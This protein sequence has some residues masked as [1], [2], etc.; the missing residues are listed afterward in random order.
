MRWEKL[1]CGLAAAWWAA[2]FLAGLVGVAAEYAA[3]RDWLGFRWPFAVIA[4]ALITWTPLNIFFC[5]AGA[6]AVWQ[7]TWWAA[8]LLA[9]PQAAVMIP[10]WVA[11]SAPRRHVANGR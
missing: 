7:W 10:Y 6:I 9:C 5:A 11:Q 8:L 4:C 1:A 2:Y 3:F